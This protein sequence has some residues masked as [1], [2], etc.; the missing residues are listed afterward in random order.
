MKPLINNYK[1]LKLI[2]QSIGLLSLGTLVHAE[3]HHVD[4]VGNC[5]GLTNCYSTI[6]QALNQAA[7]DDEIRVFPGTYTESVDLSMMGSGLGTATDGNISFIAVDGNNT[8][9]VGTVQISPATGAA[10]VHSNSFFVGNVSISGMLVT[11]VDDDGIDLDL[12]NGDIIISHVTANGNNNDGIDVEVS[13]GNHTIEV[14]HSIANNNQS[15]GLNLDGPA[16]T[17]I[18]VMNVMANGNISEGID[19]SSATQTD[20]ITVTILDSEASANGDDSNDSAGTV[21]GAAGSLTVKNLVGNNNRGPG[22]AVIDMVNTEI[23]DS[24]FN[25]NAVIEFFSGIFVISAGEFSVTRTL[26]NG[27]GAAGIEVLPTNLV[28]NELTRFEVNCSSFASNDVGIFFSNGAEPSANYLINNNNFVNHVT[29]AVHAGVNNNAVDASNNWWNHISGP[30][31]INNLGGSGD[32]ISDSL[33][34]AI[35]GAQG[36]IQYTP[37]LDAPV[38]IQ[39]YPADTI[40]ANDFD[41]NL[42]SQF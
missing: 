26:L 11:A 40:F 35:G 21:V 42:C 20:D 16:G 39:Q 7:A 30:T 1:T 8:Q 18:T 31:H 25:N 23:S 12:V 6:Q 3:T 5:N 14:L 24:T 9:A 19:V 36:V 22:L 33:D 29:A 27:N 32:R 38:D 37:F 17:Q 10:F 28:G 4:N 15:S 34:D 41:G 13:V 2:L